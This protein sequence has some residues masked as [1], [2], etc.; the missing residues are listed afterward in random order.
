MKPLG[1]TF[2]F[3]EYRGQRNKV[4]TPQEN[5]NQTQVFGYSIGQP[6]RNQWH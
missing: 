4:M 5:K 2:I 6:T 1:P 3:R